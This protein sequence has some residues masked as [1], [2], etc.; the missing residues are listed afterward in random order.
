MAT[1]PNA[2]L[3][4]AKSNMIL[5]IHS[6]ASYLS[7]PKARSR[8]GGH[9]FL[10]DGTDKAPNNGA[11]LNIS[12]IIK[13]IMSSTAKAKLG[14]LYINAREAVPCRTFLEELGHKQPAMPIQMDNST[15]LG[16]VTNNILPQRTKAMDM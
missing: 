11:I 5:D 3:T 7:K 13:S 15:T 2:I 14:A 10:S 8:A 12:Q 6:N 16:I 1:H 9:F 4:Y